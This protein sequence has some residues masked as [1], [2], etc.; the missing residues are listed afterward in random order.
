MEMLR[1]TNADL[2]TGVVGDPSKFDEFTLNFEMLDTRIQ[3]VFIDASKTF[4]EIDE[5]MAK[6][7]V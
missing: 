3:Q 7:L 5:K 2:Q 6:S 4:L 1:K